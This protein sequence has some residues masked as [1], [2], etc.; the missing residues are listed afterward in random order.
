MKI[1]TSLILASCIFA[2]AS[3]VFSQD[4]PEPDWQTSIVTF[5]ITRNNFNFRIPWDKRAQTAAK[6]GTV[7]EGN[8]ILTTAQGLANHTLVRLQKGGRGKWYSGS[9]EWVDYQANLA[10][11][12]V[13][14]AAFWEGLAPVRF[15]QADELKRNLQIVR[16]RGGNI[17]RRAAEFSRFSVADANFN[18]AP[19]IEMKTSSEME[20]AGRGELMVSG[21]RVGG[22]VASKSGSTC[23]V[24][25]TPFIMS[26]LEKRASG[27]YPGLG[28]F[29]FIWQPASNPATTKYFE[30][31]GQSGG[32][33]LIKPS[34]RP[35]AKSPLKLHDIILEI[36]GYPIDIQGDYLDPDYGHVIM[37]YLACRKKW[38]GD[39]VKLKIWRDGEKQ[40]ID[41][42]LPKA[43]FSKNLIIDGPVGKEPTYLIT[44]GLVFVPLSAEFLSSWGAD[45]QRTAPFRLVYYNKQKAKKDQPSLVVLSLVLPDSYNIG[46]QERNMQ[47]LVLDRTNGKQISNLDDL[48]EALKNPQDG[49]HVFQ[50][51]KGSAIQKIILDAG[52][53]DEANQRIAKRYGIAQ[54]QKLN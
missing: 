30:F 9:V 14:D 54:Q 42:V 32:V 49:F 16:W 48:I 53:L 36:D 12:G 52:E 31:S 34:T 11:V 21:G 24:I 4:A 19:R 28:F 37:E 41:Y 51:N 44:G 13:S 18:Q 29:D 8:E 39:I 3:V 50:F 38:A 17:E 23:S 26:I 10:V 27:D 35:G 25:P 7:I 1:K 43:D 46:Y 6:L 40:E 15:A 22:L 2:T 47:N 20:G 33:L 45:W 5:D